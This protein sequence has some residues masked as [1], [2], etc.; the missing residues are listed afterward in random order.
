MCVL[1]A[2]HFGVFKPWDCL[3]HALPVAKTVSV[4]EQAHSL[5]ELWARLE[6]AE[7]T[8]SDLKGTSSGHSLISIQRR[9]RLLPKELIDSFF[10]S[11][12]SRGSAHYFY[13]MDV[14]FLQ[15]CTGAGDRRMNESFLWHTAL[16]SRKG[17][18]LRACS[19][20]LRSGGSTRAKTS[21]HISSNWA[22]PQE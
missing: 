17:R 5:A 4:F 22:L 8:W 16:L 1:R 2:L 19:S 9:A 21:A 10:D 7:E 11:W 3:V 6:S 18:H 15:I 20:R 14:I 12:H 13:S